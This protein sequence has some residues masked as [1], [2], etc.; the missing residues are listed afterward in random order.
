SVINGYF[1]Q[2]HFCGGDNPFIK[3][4]YGSWLS[5][6]Y[7]NGQAWESPLRQEVRLLEMLVTLVFWTL[8]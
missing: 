6:S 1:A 7:R 3:P 8:T 4:E 5:E 2:S